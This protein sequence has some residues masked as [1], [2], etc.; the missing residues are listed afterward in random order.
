MSATDRHKKKMRPA[1]EGT[2]RSSCDAG[3]DRVTRGEELEDCRPALNVHLRQIHRQ[4]PD[5]LDAHSCNVKV[6]IAR[7]PTRADATGHGVALGIQMA[8]NAGAGCFAGYR[9]PVRGNQES[10]VIGGV[11]KQRIGGKS[12]N[13]GNAWRRKLT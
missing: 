3:A 13:S 4:S 5:P 12:G 6:K 10:H 7:M 2:N 11:D 8:H 1:A 9:V